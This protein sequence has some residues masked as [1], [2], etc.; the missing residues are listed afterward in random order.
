MVKSIVQWEEMSLEEELI[1]DMRE[2][3]QL[4]HGEPR[5]AEEFES[6]DN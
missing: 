1:S 4:K 5:E 2:N 3:E 6:E